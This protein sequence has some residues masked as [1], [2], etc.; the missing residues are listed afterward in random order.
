M[1][2]EW[3][4]IPSFPGYNVSNRGRVMGKY[5]ILKTFPT[6]K[7]YRKLTLRRDGK[8]HCWQVHCLVMD[9]FVGPR[10]EGMHVCHADHDKANNC[11]SNLRYDTP[12]NNVQDS[13]VAGKMAVKLDDQAVREI[14][15]FAQ[16]RYGNCARLAKK[17]GVSAWTISAVMNGRAWT[18]VK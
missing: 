9:A 1:S 16:S 15:S 13:V 5:K 17:F 18:H 14:R 4:P 2:E 8:T 6:D 7:G 10:P 12:R 3:R 11:L